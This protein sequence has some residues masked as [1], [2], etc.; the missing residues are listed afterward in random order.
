MAYMGLMP[1]VQDPAPKNIVICC[2]GTW[3]TADQRSGGEPSPTNVTKM[4]RL[5]LPQSETGG[6]QVVFYDQ[7]V[8]T[9]S[10]WLEKFKGG[11]FGKGLSKNVLDGYRFLMH[12]YK[13]GD[14][15]FLFGFSRGAYT[16]RCL[17]GLLNQVGILRKKNG[18]MVPDAWQ[19]YRG[20]NKPGD[21]RSTRFRNDFSWPEFRIKMLGVWDTVGA[22]G[23]PLG[24]FRKS[25]KRKY[26][27]HD[28]K[29]GWI[30]QHA[31]QALAIDERRKDFLPAIWDGR[32]AADQLVEQVWFPG[33]HADVGGGYKQSEGGLANCALGWMAQKASDN[34]LALDPELLE[35]AEWKPDAY[36]VMHDE[37]NSWKW[38]WRRTTRKMASEKDLGVAVATTAGLRYK[39]SGM[40]YRPAPLE[41]YLQQYPE[42]VW[43]WPTAGRQDWSGNG[44]E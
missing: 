6:E 10:G 7:G 5:V 29:L 4:A 20:Q 22:M 35:S 44:H 11:A 25:N 15:I 16:A 31:C 40:Q 3:N 42:P 32:A 2:D 19:L 43:V 38:R 13:D 26:G 39:R 34:G 33:A 27:F 12:N 17:T 14:Q 24:I 41:A 23:I 30:V 9:E 21:D 36:S 28:Q 1:R 8:G 18:Y 37:S